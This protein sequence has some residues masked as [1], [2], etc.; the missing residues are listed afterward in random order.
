MTRR[1]NIRKAVLARD[2]RVCNSCGK[3]CPDDAEVDHSI[4]LA[5]GGTDE[6]DQCRVLCKGC[7]KRKTRGDITRIAKARRV[8]KRETEFQ[9]RMREKAGGA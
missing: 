5:L 3:P 6:A 7:H 9:R 4:P 1:R 8:G 2:G